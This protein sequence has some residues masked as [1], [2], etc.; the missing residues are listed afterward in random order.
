[1][2]RFIDIHVPISSCN[3][4]CHYCYVAHEGNRNKEKAIFNYDADTIKK[5][6]SVKRMGGVCHFNIC[7]AGETL[8]PKQMLS[9]TKGIL[10]NGHYVMIVTNGT[11]TER[12]DEF[13]NFPEE[14]RIRLG[15]KFSLHYLELKRKGMLEQFAANINN[16]R[17]AGMSISIE[18]TPNDECV[19]YIFE[20]KEFC[21]NNFGALCHLTIPRNMMLKEIEL[22]SKYSIDE[23]YDIWKEFDS[24][25]LDF[26]YSLWGKKRKEYCHAGIWSGL[27]N[28]GTGDLSACYVGHIH[29]NIF[30]NPLKPINFIGIGKGCTLPHCYNG[31]SFLALGDI[32]E[33]NSI[34]YD[35]ERDRIKSSVE[36]WLNNDMR[37]FL[38][39]RLENYNE[40]LSYKEKI[41][42]E[43]KKYCYYCKIGIR[44]IVK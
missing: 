25:L 4:K 22:L 9:I 38:S 35:N 30:E 20:I 42:N 2:K 21:L 12:F 23:F 43:M 40:E 32:P 34:R 37:E 7:G 28:I 13:C 18:M 39:H 1:M 5:C 15:F 10:E 11:L 26:K 6:L 36:H 41:C 16:V 17:R 8:I 27:L 33:I 19:A 44:K 3:L 24:S 29:Q 31:H 14:L